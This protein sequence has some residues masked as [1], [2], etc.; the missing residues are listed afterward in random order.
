MSAAASLRHV[1]ASFDLFTWGFSCEGRAWR[2]AS[3]GGGGG[4]G[5]EQGHRPGAWGVQTPTR[6]KG[7]FSISGACLFL[8]QAACIS[9]MRMYC[10]PLFISI[11]QDVSC[12]VGTQRGAPTPD[13]P[14]FFLLFNF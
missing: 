2:F 3:G 9:N 8:L 5:Q 7:F 6:T 12:A 1:D 4:G 14:F 11:A 10:Y 13:L